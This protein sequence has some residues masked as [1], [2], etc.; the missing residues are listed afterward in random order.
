MPLC[1]C[2]KLHLPRDSP[3][4]GV[5][6]CSPLAYS[7]VFPLQIN[8]RLFR[9]SGELNGS[10]KSRLWAES[11]LL[12]LKL[13]EDSVQVRCQSCPSQ[14]SVGI[15]WAKAEGISLVW[16]LCEFQTTQWSRQ[17]FPGEFHPCWDNMKRS[18]HHHSNHQRED[19][20]NKQNL[21]WEHFLKYFR[22]FT[23]RRWLRW[24]HTSLT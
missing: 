6:S 5:I 22:I 18:F 13:P 10:D 3:L 8:L 11:L 12:L 16:I 14:I 2:L 15:S 19:E 9:C 23:F 20:L 1:K 17:L 24:Q 4:P 7:R 21:D